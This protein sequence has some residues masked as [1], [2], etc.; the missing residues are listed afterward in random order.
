M[1][2]MTTRIR[3]RSAAGKSAIGGSL[4]SGGS[5][6]ER[7]GLEQ[8]GVA[9]EVEERVA[10]ADLAGVAHGLAIEPWRDVDV[11]APGRG[12][13]RLQHGRERRGGAGHVGELAANGRPVV[14]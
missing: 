2:V 12:S 3:A 7:E 9:G 4:S 14:G 10:I 13:R 8:P 11:V 6:S 5:G 1:S